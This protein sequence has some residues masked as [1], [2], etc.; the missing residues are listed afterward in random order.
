MPDSICALRTPEGNLEDLWADCEAPPNGLDPQI[1]C[2]CCTQCFSSV[3]DCANLPRSEAMLLVLSRITPDTTLSDV[4][5]AQG[6]AFLWLLDSDPLQVDPCVYSTIEQRYALA[7]LYFTTGKNS[8]H[9]STASNSN[10][11]PIRMEKF[12]NR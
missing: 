2:D 7:V 8:A 3:V 12:L 1:E 4:S 5:S 11:G 9:Q 6:Q 10:Y